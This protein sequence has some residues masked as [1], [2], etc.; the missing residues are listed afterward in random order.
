[1]SIF[2]A[3]F[4]LGKI[5]K[6]TKF[7]EFKSFDDVNQMGGAIANIKQQ[8]KEGGLQLTKAQQ[9][10]LDDQQKQVEMVFELIS[11]SPQS[12]IRNAESAKIFNIRGQQLDPNQPII[13]GTQPGKKI[14]TDAFIRLA[15]KST[16][17][18]QIITNMKNMDPIDAMKEANKVIKR[19]GIYKNLNDKEAK[20]ILNETEDHIF[21]RDIKLKETDPDFDNNLATGGRA[22]FKMGRRAFLK[23]MGG[24]GAG[25]GALKSGI[26]KLAGKESAPQVAKEV[27][28]QTTKSTPP[29]YFFE[30]AETI[31]K[32]GKPDKVTY[33]D[34][35]EVHR[36]LSKDGK[37]ELELTEDLSTGSMQIKKIKPE[38]DM[39]NEDIVLEF[40]K[41]GVDV[42]SKTGKAIKEPDEYT[43]GREVTQRIYKD[44]Y[45]E[46]DF[47]E[48]EGIDEIIKEVREAPPIKKAAGGVAYMR[49]IT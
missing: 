26:L 10:F 39:I 5:P 48:G 1:M 45:N 44:N 33:Q 21:E 24:V 41:G 29:P 35:V 27:V 23:L 2:K 19:E 14:D 16:D 32:F 20:K 9:K 34:R 37:S 17:T 7:F 46:P 43:E 25:I 12:G 8:V 47:Y 18:N 11:K 38:E 15:E 36:M 40:R 31:K 42:D 22:G 3:F 49:R 28:E 30:L 13:G 6:V 4:G